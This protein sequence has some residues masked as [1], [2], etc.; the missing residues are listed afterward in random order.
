MEGANNVVH[1][2][3]ALSANNDV[4]HKRTSS[5]LNMTNKI[6]MQVGNVAG[7]ISEVVTLT[8]GSVTHAKTSSEQ[9]AD[10]VKSTTEMAQLSAEV[11][12]ILINFRDEFCGK[13]RYYSIEPFYCYFSPIVI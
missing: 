8:N 5:S 12:K 2:M 1:S 11:E 13:V 3:E 10:V 6:D 7:L 4:L 9:L